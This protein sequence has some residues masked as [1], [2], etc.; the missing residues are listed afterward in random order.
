MDSVASS[1]PAMSSAN[2]SH[3]GMALR[4]TASEAP[5]PLRSMC[6]TRLRCGQ[7][8]EEFRRLRNL[9]DEIDMSSEGVTEE[10]VA[11]AFA[12]DL[13]GDISISDAHVPNLGRLHRNDS[14]PLTSDPLPPIRRAGQ[15]FHNGMHAAFRR[16][17]QRA[18]SDAAFRL[19]IPRECRFRNAN[20]R[21]SGLSPWCRR[22]RPRPAYEDAL[23]ARPLGAPRQRCRFSNPPQE[24]LGPRR[25]YPRPSRGNRRAPT[26][27]REEARTHQ[28]ARLRRLGFPA[29]MVSFIGM[30]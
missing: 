29:T 12:E 21:L 17:A 27:T 28:A 18:R 19:Q 24:G 1:T 15:G 7:L 11:G 10:E 20:P 2:S 4:D 16:S 13:V 25:P 5:E 26:R 6:S 30:S 8:L 9:P 22:A 23:V 14:L 3:V